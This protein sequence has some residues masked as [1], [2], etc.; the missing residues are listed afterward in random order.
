M[1]TIY[2][3]FLVNRA[4]YRKPDKTHQQQKVLAEPEIW[5]TIIGFH[6]SFGHADPDATAKAVHTTYYGTTQD[7]VI[8]LIKLCEICH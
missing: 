3:Y 1:T 6:N 4:L 2:R 5:D 8:F 7:E